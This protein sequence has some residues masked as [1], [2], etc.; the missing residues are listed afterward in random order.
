MRVSHHTS[1]YAMEGRREKGRRGWS[2]CMKLEGLFPPVSV[3]VVS[4]ALAEALW[5]FWYLASQV[6]FLCCLRL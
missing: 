4:V 5:E 6:L 1:S 3:E 2:L